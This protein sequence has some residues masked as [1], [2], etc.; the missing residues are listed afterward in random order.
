MEKDLNYT[1]IVLISSGSE[2][3]RMLHEFMNQPELNQTQI[4][5]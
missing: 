4:Q 2:C 5:G 1:Y 3:P